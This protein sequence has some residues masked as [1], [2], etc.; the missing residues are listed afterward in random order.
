MCFTLIIIDLL[1]GCSEQEFTAPSTGSNTGDALLGGNPTSTVQLFVQS[2]SEATEDED[3]VYTPASAKLI[4]IVEN[5]FEQPMPDNTPV[6]WMTTIGTLDVSVSRT[7]SG[8]AEATLTFPNDYSGCCRV[9][10]MSSG[11]SDAIQVCASTNA[12]GELSSE[13]L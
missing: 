9:T 8:I 7:S 5:E 2:R 12:E 6:I 4:A 3:S 11:A 1:G 10:A 13:N